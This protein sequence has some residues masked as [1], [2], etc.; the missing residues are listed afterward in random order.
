VPNY[1]KP[2]EDRLNSS[3][4][5]QGALTPFATT[6]NKLLSRCTPGS[7]RLAD[8]GPAPKLRGT[9]Q[10]FNTPSG[11]SLTL[12]GLRGRVVLLDFFAYSCINCQRDQPFLQKWAR[13]YRA[14]G[15][16]VIG[17]HSPEFSFERDAR[18]LAKALKREGTT[19]PV[20]QDNKLSTWTAYRN[21][22][23]PAK[24]LIDK[25][26]VVRAIKFG[27]GDYAQTESMVRSLLSERDGGRR[28]PRPVS[29][30]SGPKLADDRTPELYV[31][32]NRPGYVGVPKYIG[33]GTKTYT[34]GSL[35]Q[36][37]DTY[38]LA[39]QWTTTPDGLTAGQGARLRLH[40]RAKDVFHVLGGTGTV[41]VSR[42]GEPDRVID[43]KGVPNLYRVVGGRGVV[44]E[45]VT[46]TYSGRVQVYTFTF[47]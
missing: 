31:A 20:V 12:A 42:P 9:G 19:Y 25:N 39:G 18:N 40:F 37:L 17:V 21:R 2:L 22:Y 27:E 1:T 46:L 4:T 8:C 23:W 29:E 26:G 6:E 30:T 5:V 11:Q 45:T 28:L 43:V 35:S 34:F 10:W 44:N 13:T 32:D 16:T 47:G 15:L 38:G 33:A 14:A 41:T 36:P 24:Y 7:T 3:D